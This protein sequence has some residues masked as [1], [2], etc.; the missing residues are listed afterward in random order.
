LPALRGCRSSPCAQG[1]GMV[2][3]ASNAY[4]AVMLHFRRIGLA[5]LRH[6]RDYG[7]VARAS[8][9]IGIGGTYMNAGRA[10]RLCL[11]QGYGCV[12]TAPALHSRD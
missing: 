11:P 12:L 7:T 3:L 6:E 1:S 2:K 8:A 9:W 10:R 5:L 4:L